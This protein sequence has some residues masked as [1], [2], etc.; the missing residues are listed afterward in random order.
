MRRLDDFGARGGPHRLLRGLGPYE[1][2]GEGGGSSSGSRSAGGAAA[3][4]CRRPRTWEASASGLADLLWLSGSARDDLKVRLRHTA[5]LG[6]VGL[7]LPE[8][9]GPVWE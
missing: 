2:L 7:R 4:C 6:P 1:L 5:V 3:C 8:V 9:L